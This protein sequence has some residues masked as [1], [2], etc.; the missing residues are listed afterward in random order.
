MSVK[1]GSLI[2]FAVLVTAAPI[3]AQAQ[4][5]AYRFTLPPMTFKGG[6]YKPY[7]AF[8]LP[9]LHTLWFRQVSFYRS[10]AD[11]T[12]RTPITLPTMQPTSRMRWDLTPLVPCPPGEHRVWGSF[13]EMPAAERI[14]ASYT[15]Y[16]QSSLCAPVVGD[17]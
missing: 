4:P 7:S 15:G 8:H 5:P 12:D 17:P 13:G 9:S 11:Q 10:S 14:I 2:S 16:M 6:Q 3:V 1:N